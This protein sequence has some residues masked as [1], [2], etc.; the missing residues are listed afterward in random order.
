[1]TGQIAGNSGDGQSNNLSAAIGCGEEHKPD[2]RI[3]LAVLRPDCSGS[4]WVFHISRIAVAVAVAV[5][6]AATVAAARA[7]ARNS[8]DIDPSL[9]TFS[10]AG[11]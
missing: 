8:R 9:C 5:A 11:K 4:G 2:D 3:D 10:P 1:M 6:A 7:G